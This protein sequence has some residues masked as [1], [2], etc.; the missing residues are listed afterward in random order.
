MHRGGWGYVGRV[1][2]WTNPFI[3]KL[4]GINDSKILVCVELKSIFGEA[5]RKNNGHIKNLFLQL[6]QACPA[7]FV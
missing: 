2:G 4:V 6:F 1:Q 5:I 3:V 7:G